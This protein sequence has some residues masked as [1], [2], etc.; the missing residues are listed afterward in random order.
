MAYHNDPIGHSLN[1]KGVKRGR[2]ASMPKYMDS[3]IR[4]TK[5]P[6][7]VEMIGRR[8]FERQ[9]GNTYHSVE[10]YVDGQFVGKTDFQYG[11]DDQ[12]IVTGFQILKEKGYFVN[13][14]YSDLREY[15]RNHNYPY[16]FS[17][18]DVSRKKDL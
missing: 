4:V 13:G 9:N 10:V 5:I 11:Y 7:R 17:V 6:K 18:S 16:L 1:A 2:T 12:Y 8:W 15:N 14:E 3:K